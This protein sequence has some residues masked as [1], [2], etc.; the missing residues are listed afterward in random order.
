VI[1]AYRELTDRGYQAGKMII[2]GE[3]A[4]GGLA[5]AATLAILAGG[6]APPAAV[7]ALSPWCDLTLHNITLVANEGKD[8]ML[9]PG[10][11]QLAAALY[12]GGQDRRDPF[13]S[14]AFG[15]YNG[16]PPLHMQV[17]AEELLLGETID[18]ANRAR[19]SGATVQ[20]E[21]FDG[22]W[23]VWQTLDELIPE[24]RTA[25]DMI[26]AFTRGLSWPD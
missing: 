17:A 24:A 15:D 18:L 22:M 2:I 4:G 25:L 13:I 14:P 1:A 5:L 20:L 16:F 10:F 7:I 8:I 11:L 12:A 19:D 26:G 21:I 23:H 9:T 3:S 6:Y